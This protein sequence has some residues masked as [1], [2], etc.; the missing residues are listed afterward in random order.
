M[1]EHEVAIF[2]FR[3]PH[4][5]LMQGTNEFKATSS[6]PTKPWR[7]KVAPRKFRSRQLYTIQRTVLAKA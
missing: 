5:F 7:T 3:E 2:R 6:G 1:G 4:P